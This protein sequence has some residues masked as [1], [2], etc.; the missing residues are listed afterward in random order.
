VATQM[1]HNHPIPGSTPGSATMTEVETWDTSNNGPKVHVGQ[2]ER[3]SM[4][5][6]NACFSFSE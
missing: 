2:P 4:M 5:L 6:F 3:E 1:A